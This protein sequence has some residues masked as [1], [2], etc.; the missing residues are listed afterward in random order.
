[1]SFQSAG[2]HHITAIAVDPQANIDFYTRVLGLRLVKKTVNFDAPDVYHLYY[3]DHSGNPGTILTFFPFVDAG[4]GRGGA[5]QASAIRFQ[6]PA[7]DLEPMMLKLAEHGVDCTPPF[8]RYGAEVLAFKDPEGLPLEIVGVDAP[9]AGAPSPIVTGFDSLD[10]NVALPERTRRLLIDGFGYRQTAEEHG[11]ERLTVAGTGF[12][13]VHVDV[14]TQTDAVRG[15]LGGGTVHH[16][17][18][19]AKDE[20]DLGA[21]RRHVSGLGFEVTPILD[22][23]YFKSIYF[24][25]PGGILFEIATD[26]PG[27]AIDEPVDALGTALKLPAWL[28]SRRAEI[29]RRL[30][31]LQS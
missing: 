8:Q 30:P 27:F 5:G 24:R 31:P 11:R 6:T 16:V 4:P 3:G 26:P 28:E 25:E 7:A 15:R 19:R 12:P 20:G 17:A 21:W 2:L 1:M 29:E 14:V 23:Q 13:G 22:R 9:S 18:F 10:L